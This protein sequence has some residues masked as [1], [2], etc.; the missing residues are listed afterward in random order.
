ME[1]GLITRIE[2][3]NKDDIDEEIKTL[4]NSILKLVHIIESKQSKNE[5]PK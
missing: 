3:I 4:V 2:K 5:N 1:N